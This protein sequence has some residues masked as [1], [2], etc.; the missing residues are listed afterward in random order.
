MD[1]PPFP[2]DALDLHQRQRDRVQSVALQTGEPAIADRPPIGSV[3]RKRRLVGEAA[4]R[5]GALAGK[6]RLGLI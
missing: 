3:R 1:G 4:Q 5:G 2:G 6:E